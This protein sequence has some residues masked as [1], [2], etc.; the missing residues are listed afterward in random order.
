MKRN[1]LE[2]HIEKS[3]KYAQVELGKEMTDIILK[4][5]GM[6][7]NG[8]MPVIIVLCKAGVNLEKLCLSESITIT[9]NMSTGI[10]R[11]AGKRD[12][13]ARVSSLH[14][15]TPDSLVQEYIKK[16]AG[17]LMTTRVVYARYKQGALIG[18]LNNDCQYQVDLSEA[19]M[20]MGTF[21]SLDGMMVKIFYRGN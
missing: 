9:K 7:V 16:L 17:K 2:V 21:H 12:V 15:N 19:T 18:K 20:K 14:W 5:I 3:D 10:I 4:S 13:M 8:I 1:V 6:N 11:P